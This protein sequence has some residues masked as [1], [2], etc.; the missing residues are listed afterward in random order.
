MRTFLM[1]AIATVL[2]ASA[3]PHRAQAAPWCAVYYSFSGENR[4]CGFAS[5]EQCRRNMSSGLGETCMRNPSEPTATQRSG[6]T[7]AYGSAGRRSTY[8]Y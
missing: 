8:R 7:R 5:F 4:N 1:L 2:C 6:A 3:A